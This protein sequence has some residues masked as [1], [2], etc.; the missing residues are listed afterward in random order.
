MYKRIINK[1]NR[2]FNLNIKVSK[3]ANIAD[4]VYSPP[5]PLPTQDMHGSCLEFGANPYFTT[6][7]L[8]EFTPSICTMPKASEN[9]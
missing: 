7:L 6:M 3:E 9:G 2:L 8:K 1:L 4:F 5:L